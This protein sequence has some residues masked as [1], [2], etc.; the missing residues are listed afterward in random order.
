MVALAPTSRPRVAF[1]R[2]GAAQPH[3]DAALPLSSAWIEMTQVTPQTQTHV[4][5]FPLASILAMDQEPKA[6]PGAMVMAAPSNC[7]PARKARGGGEA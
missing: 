1:T 3:D 5:R 2:V 4:A 7:C 6:A